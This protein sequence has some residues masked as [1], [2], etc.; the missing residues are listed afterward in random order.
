MWRPQASASKAMRKPRRALAELPQVGGGA[1][2]TAQR[3]G[4]HGAAQ[5]QKIAAELLQDIELALGAGEGA[6][7]LL[8]WHAFEVAERLQ[9]DDGKACFA[10]R[11]RHIGGR[12]AERDE[13]VLEDLD[14]VEAG[15]GDRFELLA[16]R[17]AERYRRDRGLH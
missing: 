2:D 3:I 12:A 14:R 15:I 13:I 9:G 6:L 8:R 17:A 5:H 4:R 7:A 10:A 11:V 16:Q 1:V